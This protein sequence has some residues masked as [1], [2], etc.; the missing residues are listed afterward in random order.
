MCHLRVGVNMISMTSHRA[1]FELGDLLE[2]F[3]VVLHSKSCFAGMSR[4]R[5][6]HIGLL[7]CNMN[8][9]VPPP[10]GG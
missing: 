3:D 2:S 5:R 8:V 9:K 7:R 1:S 4:A 10:L 6:N